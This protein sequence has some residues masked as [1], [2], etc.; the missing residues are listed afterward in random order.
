MDDLR[1]ERLPDETRLSR[2]R[3]LSGA[4]GGF[5]LAAS[6]LLVPEDVAAEKP[7]ERILNDPPSATIATTRTATTRTATTR[8]ATT[9]TGT[10]RIAT[11]TTATRTRT[12]PHLQ[13]R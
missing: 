4:G 5:M 3:L 9:M 6:G 8:T 2:R 7:V 11:R 13:L 1:F 12:S 10:T